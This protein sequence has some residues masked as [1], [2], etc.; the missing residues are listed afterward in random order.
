MSMKSPGARPMMNEAVPNSHTSRGP[1][2]ALWAAQVLLA[3]AFL[4]A[5]GANSP[6]RRP[7]PRNLM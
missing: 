7:W 2:V 5:D 3:A 1:S 6:V 4:A